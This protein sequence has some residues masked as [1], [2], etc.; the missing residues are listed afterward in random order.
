[1]AIVSIKFFMSKQ[2]SALMLDSPSK[3]R[4]VSF[5]FSGVARVDKVGAKEGGVWGRSPQENF[6]GHV[7]YFG[8][9]RIS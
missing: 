2:L 3:L 1:M 5:E 9:E 8:V 6:W 4:G 7:L